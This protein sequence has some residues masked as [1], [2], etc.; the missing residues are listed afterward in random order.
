LHAQRKSQNLKNLAWFCFQSAVCQRE[1]DKWPHFINYSFIIPEFPHNLILYSSQRGRLSFSWHGGRT[2]ALS[3][4]A[5]IE[6]LPWQKNKK[7]A[8][9]HFPISPCCSDIKQ[10]H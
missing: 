2:A 1:F 5:T 3:G 4:M 6:Q 8:H 7:K 10:R 9:N